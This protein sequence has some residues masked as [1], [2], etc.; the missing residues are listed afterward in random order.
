MEESQINNLSFEVN[1]FLPYFRDSKYGITIWPLYNQ[2]WLLSLGSGRVS[3]PAT[4]EVPKAKLTRPCRSLK[5]GALQAQ[6]R[7]G[8][9][10]LEGGPVASSSV[11]VMTS[12]HV[13]SPSSSPMT[14]SLPGPAPL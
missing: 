6:L 3:M 7:L 11:R 4:V 13:T 14:G 2:L 12:C 9:L 1:L 5:P 8:R 10:P